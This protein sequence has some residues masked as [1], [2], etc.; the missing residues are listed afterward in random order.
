MAWR[1]PTN[2][3]TPGFW[4]QLMSWDRKAKTLRY[5][6]E[7]LNLSLRRLIFN[8]V[9]FCRIGLRTKSADISKSH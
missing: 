6:E 7:G 8:L 3:I 1:K 9:A 5:G 2:E 4:Q